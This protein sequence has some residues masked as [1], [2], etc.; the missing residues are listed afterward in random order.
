MLV[1][2]MLVVV[3]WFVWH[4]HMKAPSGVVVVVVMFVVVTSVT[5]VVLGVVSQVLALRESFTVTLMI[6]HNSPIY[7]TCFFSNV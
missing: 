4:V 3:M 1:V 5:A 7:V 6:Y 2:V